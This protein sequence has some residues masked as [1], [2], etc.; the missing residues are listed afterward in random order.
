MILTNNNSEIDWEDTT[1]E[2]KKQVPG[3]MEIELVW[4]CIYRN[5]GFIAM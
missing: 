3:N 2:K 1:Y 4:T 5:N